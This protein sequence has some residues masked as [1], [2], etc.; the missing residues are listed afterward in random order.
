MSRNRRERDP[1]CELRAHLELA[2]TMAARGESPEA[3]RLAA[4]REFTLALGI[5]RQHGALQLGLRGDAAVPRGERSRRTPT[6]AGAGSAPARR[7]PL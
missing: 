5:G 2:R 4:L 3:A 7:R 1:D 6:A